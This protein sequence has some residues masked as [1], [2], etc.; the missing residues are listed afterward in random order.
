MYYRPA[1][2]KF[3]TVI[4]VVFVFLAVIVSGGCGG[5]S[6]DTAQEVPAELLA[7]AGYF[8]KYQPC[9]NGKDNCEICFK[10]TEGTSLNWS[11]YESQLEKLFGMELLEIAQIAISDDSCEEDVLSQDAADAANNFET[12]D[13][14]Q[15]DPNSANGFEA[16]SL[17]QDDP[18]AAGSLAAD[19]QLGISGT[20]DSA[21]YDLDN[22]IEENVN[23]AVVRVNNFADSRKLQVLRFGDNSG[24]GTLVSV[25]VNFM[26]N[27]PQLRD[28][29]EMVIIPGQIRDIGASAFANMPKLRRVIIFGT[30]DIDDSA[31]ANCPE[32]E[33]VNIGCGDY[34]DMYRDIT[35]NSGT[36]P[37]MQKFM[38][39]NKDVKYT[40]GDKAFA[41]CP[42]LK[43]MDFGFVAPPKFGSDVFLGKSRA[44]QIYI[45]YPS[46][47]GDFADAIPSQYGN[48]LI[49]LFFTVRKKSWMADLP[50]DQLITQLSIPG[51]HDSATYGLDNIIEMYA[52]TQGLDF[53]N[54]FSRG[55]RCFDLR[56]GHYTHSEL[57]LGHAFSSGVKFSAAMD[58]I[59]KALTN[60]PRDFAIIEFAWDGTPNAKKYKEMQD[61]VLRQNND[62]RAVRFKPD[63]RLKDVR[64]KFLFI[65]CDVNNTRG[66]VLDPSICCRWGSGS[67]G[68]KYDGSVGLPDSSGKNTSWSQNKWS[69]D[70]TGSDIQDK[71]NKMNEMFDK[72]AQ[73]VIAHPD[74]SLWCFNFV[75]GYI[76]DEFGK[77]TNYPWNAE[78]QNRRAIDHIANLDGPTGIV[79]M[80][81]AGISNGDSRT[82]RAPAGK[83]YNV[84]GDLLLDAVINHNFKF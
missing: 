17:P 24:S 29:V 42:K 67:F 48:R 64:G 7:E 3:L 8:G 72:F 57:Y 75:S 34:R 71:T 28:S 77:A 74:E 73:H 70:K 51:T 4:F 39:E 41:N 36:H 46:K 12:A 43:L 18:N 63:L 9:D 65:N 33:I 19:A 38:R 5:S 84:N 56:L 23:N 76:K 47:K 14:P 80:D 25:P 32:L 45:P 60:Y 30:P 20:H 68:L 83:K 58:T 66:V 79:Y 22:I 16:A 62:A 11:E 26:Q 61:A 13:L 55:V 27:N 21:T 10:L 31:F 54:Q 2:F 1:K 81:F 52:R 49:R 44:P 6:Y 53:Y 35:D 15:E 82:K 59:K 78:Y 40:I 50:D 69:V 37:S